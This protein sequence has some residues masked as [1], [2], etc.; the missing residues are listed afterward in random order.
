MSMKK[1]KVT[2]HTP[3]GLIAS[4][5]TTIGVYQKMPGYRLRSTKGALA[6]DAEVISADAKRAYTKSRREYA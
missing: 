1:R 4:G 3:L 6:H 5:V 2:G